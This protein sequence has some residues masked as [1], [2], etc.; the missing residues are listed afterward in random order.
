[1]CSFATKFK[2]YAEHFRGWSEQTN[3]MHQYLC[4]SCPPLCQR[5]SKGRTL[6]DSFGN[7]VWTALEA[8]GF[9]ANLQHYNPLIDVRIATQY[10][11]PENWLLKAELV[12]GKPIGGPNPD[13][14][15]KPLEERVKVF[16]AKE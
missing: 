15:F 11:V 2:R 10:N 9:G 16:G 12:F 5:V 8:E 13:K 6:A 3:G 1:M 14:E 4:T 7:I